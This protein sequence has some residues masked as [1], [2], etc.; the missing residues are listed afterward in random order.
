MNEPDGAMKEPECELIS[1]RHRR[2]IFFRILLV[3]AGTVIAHRDIRLD[4]HDDH[5][6]H[7]RTHRR[8]DDFRSV[9]TVLKIFS[10]PPE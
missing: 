1:Q 2:N 7:H 8:N 4:A 10:S 9:P 5:D 3:A 6:L